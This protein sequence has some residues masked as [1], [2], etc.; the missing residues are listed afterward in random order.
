MTSRQHRAAFA[1]LEGLWNSAIGNGWQIPTAI[2]LAT[3][4]F[5][6]MSMTKTDPYCAPAWA[7]AYNDPLGL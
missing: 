4:N 3:A 1:T 5:Q 7:P 6:M 2:S